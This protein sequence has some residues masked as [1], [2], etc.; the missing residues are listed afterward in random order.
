MIHPVHAFWLQE[1]SAADLARAV[2]IGG[3]NV[4]NAVPIAALSRDSEPGK[5][6]TSVHAKSRT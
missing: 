3:S 6:A 2:I 5:G 1:G 4:G